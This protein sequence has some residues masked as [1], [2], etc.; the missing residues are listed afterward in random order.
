MN[1][2]RR[3]PLPNL[4]HDLLQLLV[5]RVDGS[6]HLDAEGRPDDGEERRGEGDGAVGQQRHV[7]RDETLLLLAKGGG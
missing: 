3:R 2:R 1:D 5:R 7:H 4:E 6:L